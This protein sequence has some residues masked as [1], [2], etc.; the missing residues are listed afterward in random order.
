MKII[1]LGALLES[2]IQEAPKGKKPAGAP[3]QAEPQ[4][5]PQAGAEP[6]GNDA[7]DQAHKLDLVSAGWG[8]WKDKSGQIVAKTIDGHLVKVDPNNRQQKSDHETAWNDRQSDPENVCAP[9]TI[10]DASY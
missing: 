5:E 8:R 4:A 1:K 6:S 2:V 7:A 9:A 3:Q 10:A